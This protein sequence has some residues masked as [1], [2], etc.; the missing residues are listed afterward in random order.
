ML[1]SGTKW[2][3]EIGRRLVLK[4]LIPI[5][6]AVVVAGCT[7]GATPTQ[8]TIKADAAKAGSLFCAVQTAGGGAIVVAVID[9]AATAAAPAAAPVAVIATGAGKA[10][11]DA[12]CA[13]AAANVGA[14]AGVPVSPPAAGTVVPQVAV[15]VAKP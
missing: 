9:A 5:A 6:A 11:V 4:H 15:V 10:L 3:E 12:A 7:P 1:C 14:T 13:Q 2:A 8:Q